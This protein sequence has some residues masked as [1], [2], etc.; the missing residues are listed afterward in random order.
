MN[1]ENLIVK[2]W[3][4]VEVINGLITPFGS[5]IILAPKDQENVSHVFPLYVTRSE[6]NLIF[7]EL[8]G[9]SFPRPLSYDLII[10]LFIHFKAELR[11]AFITEIKDDVCYAQ[12]QWH[13]GK[14]KNFLMDCRPSDAIILALKCNAPFFINTDL[15][16]PIEEFLDESNKET[17]KISIDNILKEA[18]KDDW[19]KKK[20]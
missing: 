1:Y 18:K 7:R 20:N 15:L 16:I 12:I 19:G 4:E 9:Y 10:R 2:R 14:S 11:A 5:V 6:A 3:V 8:N 17:D 13:Q